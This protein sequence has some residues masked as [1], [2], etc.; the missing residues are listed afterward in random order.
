M[1][2]FQ[3]TNT[4]ESKKSSIGVKAVFESTT[5]SEFQVPIVDSIKFTQL[6]FL[7]K[8][9]LKIL[10]GTWCGYCPRVSYAASLVEE[11]TDKVFVV[12]VH[13]GDQMANSFW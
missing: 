1:C 11:Q 9:L 12:G 10:P 13:N 3:E 6:V 7:K 5:S 8:Q 2:L 4:L